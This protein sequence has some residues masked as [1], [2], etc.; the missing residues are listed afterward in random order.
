METMPHAETPVPTPGEPRGAS[1]GQI[2]VMF[3]IF[4]VGLMGMLGLATDLGMA[5]AQRRTMQNSAD[6]GALAGG[7]ALVKYSK[8]N[9]ISA[10]PDV[11]TFVAANRMDTNPQITECVYLDYQGNNQGSCNATVTPNATGVRV[12]VSEV[13]NTTFIRVIPGMP[14]Q[15]TVTA[16]A[17]AHVYAFNEFPNESPFIVCGSHSWAVIDKNGTYYPNPGID[18][19]I[20]KPGN[21]AELNPDAVGVTFFVQH[22]QLS[23]GTG[24]KKDA[25][26]DTLSARFNGITNQDANKNKSGNQW[27]EYTEG[28]DAGPTR[29]AVNG[30]KGCQLGQN[31]DCVMFIPIATNNPSEISAPAPKNVFV[32]GYAAFWVTR[33]SSNG[34]YGK[35]MDDYIVSGPSDPNWCRDCMVGGAVVRLSG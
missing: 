25:G 27:F 2:I 26:C 32:V 31:V 4:L 19:P 22:N 16:T 18:I 30:I 6:A 8:T 33:E 17:T 21:N 10:E 9:P 1:R 14:N 15:V 13:H 3:A 24:I 12:S 28:T 5:Y 11:Q 7:R 23:Q 20:L 35:L 34:H 29:E